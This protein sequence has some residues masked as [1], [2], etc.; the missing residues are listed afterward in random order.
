VATTSTNGARTALENDGVERCIRRRHVL[1]VDD[2]V[3]GFVAKPFDPGVI[4]RTAA[5]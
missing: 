1:L 4:E 2:D 3:A 5:A